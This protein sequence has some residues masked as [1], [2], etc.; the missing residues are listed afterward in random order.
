[1]EE[2]VASRLLSHC[3]H[4]LGTVYGK[5][6]CD[7]IK[8]KAAA[9][10]HLA[11][12]GSGVLV[13]TD[14]LDT[15]M[16]CICEA[17]NKYVYNK[18]SKPPKNY[19]FRFS[20]NE[21]ESWL[22]ADREG[23]AAFFAVNISNVTKQPENEVTPKTTLINLARKSNKKSINQGIAPPP[24]HFASVGPAYFSLMSKFILEHWNI[25]NAIEHAQSL[26]RCINRLQELN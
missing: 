19:L 7:Y 17:L 16:E 8:E 24:N 18:I 23:I 14:F 11:K 6:G 20:V 13:L 10:H 4:E 9:F 21:L 2:V 3:G 25:E 1:M 12:P 5:R 26:R 22:L 15:K